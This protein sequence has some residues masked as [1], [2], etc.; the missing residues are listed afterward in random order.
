MTNEKVSLNLSIGASNCASP[1]DR[2]GIIASGGTAEEVAPANSNRAG[3][4][5]QNQ[6]TSDLWL[7]P[8][9]TATASAA[10]PNIRLSAGAYYEMPPNSAFTGAITVFGAKS[11]QVFAAREW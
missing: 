11:G 6:S 7:N 8:D 4:W 5:L 3:F 10:P 9:G 1:V 2:S